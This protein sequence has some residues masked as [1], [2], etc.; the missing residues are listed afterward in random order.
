ERRR[1]GL[2]A[3]PDLNARMRPSI[4]HGRLRVLADRREHVRRAG[5]R[6]S[7]GRDADNGVRLSVEDER[8]GQRW[9][10][11]AVLALPQGVTDDRDWRSARLIL[12]LQEVAAL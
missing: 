8:P 6:E 11:A 5:H 3:S 10:A 12:G 7:R 9:N 4:A 1:I 2:Q